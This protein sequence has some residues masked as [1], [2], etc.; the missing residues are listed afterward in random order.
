MHGKVLRSISLTVASILCLLVV[1][2][3]ALAGPPLLCHP[4]GIGNARSLPWSGSEW[5]GVDKSYAV[6]RLIGDTV[7]FLTPETPGIV[8]MGTLGRATEYALLSTADIN[9]N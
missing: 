5:R 3:A 2:Q 9:V 1:Q 4:F 8:R 7:A 6:N